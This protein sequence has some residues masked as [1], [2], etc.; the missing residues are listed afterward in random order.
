MIVLGV[1]AAGNAG[2]ILLKTRIAVDW[3][4]SDNTEHVQQYFCSSVTR[5]VLVQGKE[6]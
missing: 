2:H 3:W 1:M 5:Y 4:G 6:I